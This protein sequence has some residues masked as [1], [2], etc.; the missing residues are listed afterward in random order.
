MG[1]KTSVLLAP[2]D[3]RGNLLHWTDQKTGVN[4]E[5]KP[6]WGGSVVWQDNVPFTGTLTLGGVTSGRSAKYVTWRAPDGRTFP[7]FVSDLVDFIHRHRGVLDAG[8]VSA[9]WMVSKRGT[10]YGIRLAK[11]DE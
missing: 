2:Y 4:K 9:R 6:G 3:A 5:A 1:K 8:I 10:N 7:M 11:D